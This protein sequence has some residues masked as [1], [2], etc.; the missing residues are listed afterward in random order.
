MAGGL[1]CAAG[2]LWF[3]LVPGVE[4]DY[5]RAWLPG[6]VLTGLGTGMALPSLSG[7]AVARLEP[8]RFG[9]G[10]AVNQ[11][12]RQ[13]GAVLGVALTVVLVG[14]AAPGLADFRL[15][16]RVQIGLMLLTVA[17][18]A[19][20]DTRPRRLPIEPA[21]APVP[22]LAMARMRQRPDAAHSS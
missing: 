3:L 6:M 20:V 22:A 1:V 8:A 21:P 17:L 5:L 12:V 7:A 4:P 10:S 19:R 11:A 13:V 14:K 16:Y 15:L 18:S 2:G 9:V